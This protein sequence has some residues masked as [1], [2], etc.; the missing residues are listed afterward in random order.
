MEQRE[1]VCPLGGD[2]TN[3]CADCVYGVDYHYDKELG[4]C[5][6]RDL[7]K[8]IETRTKHI[9]EQVKKQ[10]E[11]ARKTFYRQEYWNTIPE[12]EILG[13][14]IAKYCEWKGSKILKVMLSALEDAN[15]HTLASEIEALTEKQKVIP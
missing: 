5:V 8:N 7:F 3:D 6:E 14:I 9:L 4:E 10:I 13:V 2:I 11:I 12:E 15:Y 1:D